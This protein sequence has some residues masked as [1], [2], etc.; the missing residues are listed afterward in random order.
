MKAKEKARA[1]NAK[2]HEHGQG[3][4]VWSSVLG[5]SVTATSAEKADWTEVDRELLVWLVQ[6]VSK[7]EGAV[8]LGTSRDGTQFHVKIYG[9]DQQK[10]FW[11]A[12]HEGGLALLHEWISVFC[13]GLEAVD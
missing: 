8:L 12:G 2:I 9:G 7:H 6:T 1:T 4:S 3:R 13:Q 5:E 11:F 10:N